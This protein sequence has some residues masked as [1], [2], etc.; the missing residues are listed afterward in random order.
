[1]RQIQ[2]VTVGKIKGA[3]R[4]L[5]TGIREYEKRLSRHCAIAWTEIPEE[6]PTPTRTVD[7]IRDREAEGILKHCAGADRIV[8]LSERGRLMDSP[9]FSQWLLGGN[10]LDGGRTPEM[11][12]RMIIIIGGA[13]GTSPRLADMA[14]DVVSL[15]PLTFPHQMVRLVLLEQLYRAWTIHRN[16]PYHK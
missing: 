8:L 4:Y 11:W 9:A 7:Q 3:A 10:P 14:T 15:S 16:E 12:N 5:E 1:M 2:I 13:Y 6:S